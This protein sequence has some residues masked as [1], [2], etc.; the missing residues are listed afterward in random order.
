MTK[1]FLSIDLLLGLIMIMRYM[2][3][4]IYF[5]QPHGRM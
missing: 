2:L 3:D 4:Q 5:L 1:S